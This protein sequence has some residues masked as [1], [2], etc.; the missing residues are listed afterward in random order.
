MKESPPIIN[1][2]YLKTIQQMNKQ[3]N[4]LLNSYK[5]LNNLYRSF[6]NYGSKQRIFDEKGNP[7]YFVS[8]HNSENI[9]DDTNYKN[10]GGLKNSDIY[11]KNKKEREERER[12]R[13]EEE[14]RKQKKEILERQLEYRKALKSKINQRKPEKVEEAL[15]DMSALGSIM[16][17]E[18][19]EEKRNN[20]E[21]FI[22]IENAVKEENKDKEIFC[23]GILAQCLEDIGITTAIEKKSSNDPESQNAANTVLQFIMNGMIEKKNM[24]CILI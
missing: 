23:L 17:E 8:L 24:K 3:N 4:Y 12:K 18:I 14:I 6:S 16:K 9:Y 22:S 15:K 7:Y 21:K 13:K 2:A 11:M 19:I 10:E 1:T 5:N 20:P